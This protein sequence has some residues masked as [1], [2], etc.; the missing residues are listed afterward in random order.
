MEESVTNLWIVQ[1]TLQGVSII[2]NCRF[3]V[4]LI[5]EYVSKGQCGFWET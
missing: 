3:F 4:I 1:A 5:E 2:G